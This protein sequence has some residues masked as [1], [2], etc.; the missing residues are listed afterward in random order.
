MVPFCDPGHFLLSRW[1]FEFGWSA[2]FKSGS[3]AEDNEVELK[4]HLSKGFGR[5]LI[6]LTNPF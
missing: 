2:R 6:F 1:W 4:F 3:V 5:L